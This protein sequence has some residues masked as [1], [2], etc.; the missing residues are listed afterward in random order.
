PTW[1]LILSIL[2]SLW[3]ILKLTTLD[4]SLPKELPEE[5]LDDP[6]STSSSKN[7][8]PLT[9]PLLLT[10]I[11]IIIPEIALEFGLFLPLRY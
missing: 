1:A 7:R 6:D 10:F 3:A 5:I 4:T 11:A 8:F 9:R 2:I